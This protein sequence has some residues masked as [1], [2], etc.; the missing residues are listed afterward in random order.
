M[1]FFL[2]ILVQGFFPLKIEITQFPDGCCLNFFKIINEFLKLSKATTLYWFT[3]Q[4]DRLRFF[5]HCIL[6]TQFNYTDKTANQNNKIKNQKKKQIYKSDICIIIR[7]VYT[8]HE[9]SL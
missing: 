1:Q 9:D 6:F 4:G 2:I 8:E 7:T 5:F 3:M